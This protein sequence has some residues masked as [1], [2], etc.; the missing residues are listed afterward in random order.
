[1]RRPEGRTMSVRV[2]RPSGTKWKRDAFAHVAERDG[3]SCACC[4]ASHRIIWRQMGCWSGDRWGIDPWESWRFTKVIPTS[5]LELDH[6]LPLSEGGGNSYSNLWLLCVNCHKVKT[7]SERS[8]R[9]KRLF[10][11]ARA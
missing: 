8:A 10:A 11:D 2:K 6:R 9:L 4:A 5:N 3:L 7:S 1:M